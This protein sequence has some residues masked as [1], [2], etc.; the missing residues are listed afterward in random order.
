M[1]DSITPIRVRAVQQVIKVVVHPNEA[2]IITKV[3][4]QA[5]KVKVTPGYIHP[6]V[7]PASM[8]LQDDDHQFITAAEREILLKGSTYT[9]DQQTSSYTWVI[10]HNLG[11]YPAVSI[12]DSSG[13]LVVG[14]VQYT[15]NNI[16]TLTFKAKFAG[17][18]YLN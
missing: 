16:V 17:K 2:K 13:R 4:Q 3:E 7:H 18:A 6:K 1:S 8:I 11:R 12:V 5:I 10:E 9:H 15:S 14:N